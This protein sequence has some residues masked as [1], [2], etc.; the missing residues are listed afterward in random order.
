MTAQNTNHSV[1]RLFEIGLQCT[2]FHIWNDKWAND[3]VL[4][5][6]ENDVRVQCKRKSMINFVESQNDIKLIL[7]YILIIIQHEHECNN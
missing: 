6:S 5:S 1:E 2:M 4:V 3:E 7:N